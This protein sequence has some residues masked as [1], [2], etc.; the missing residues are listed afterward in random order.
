MDGFMEFKKALQAHF[1]EMQKDADKLFEVLVDKDELWNTYLNSFPA[2][3]NPIFRERTEHDCS[4]CRHF[5]KSIGAAIIIKD[6]QAHT[7]WELK[8]N[9]PTYRTVANALDKFVKAH[10]VSDIY[11]SKFK[12]I[13]TDHNFEEIDGK[14]HR[15]D[16]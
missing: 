1:N 8:L 13:G 15:W 14:A 4:C 16:H 9:D 6:G 11:L 12:Q 3:T 10:A 5:I 2:G 7:I